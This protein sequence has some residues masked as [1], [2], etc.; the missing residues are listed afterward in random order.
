MVT[1]IEGF[2]EKVC[3][4]PHSL[5]I[6]LEMPGE[7][8]C[9]LE[10]MDLRRKTRSCL[11]WWGIWLSSGRGDWYSPTVSHGSTRSGTQPRPQMLL[12]HCG[13]NQNCLSWRQFE[14]CHEK[15]IFS[16]L[17]TQCLW[18]IHSTLTFHCKGTLVRFFAKNSS[19]M[20]WIHKRCQYTHTKSSS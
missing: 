10:G 18:N 1:V 12:L 14:S 11:W 6:T 20:P 7:A 5:P 4:A 15:E 2:M 3:L 8:T 16:Y 13:V 19:F 9:S 17:S